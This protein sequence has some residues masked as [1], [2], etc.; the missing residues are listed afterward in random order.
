ME[1]NFNSFFNYALTDK[2]FDDFV[3]NSIKKLEK[4]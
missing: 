4:D 1:I 3:T 2:G